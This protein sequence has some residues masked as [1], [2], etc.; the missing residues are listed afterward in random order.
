LT[1]V[2]RSTR[3]QVVTVKALLRNFFL[4]QTE[5]TV[6]CQ[7][8]EFRQVSNLFAQRDI[9]VG[10]HILPLALKAHRIKHLDLFLVG[11]PMRVDRWLSVE[12]LQMEMPS[13]PLHTSSGVGVTCATS[14]IKTLTEMYL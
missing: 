13:N 2:P 5:F 12:K 10:L 11:E 3:G 7:V 6:L 9:Q 1:G 14:W 8:F 4:P